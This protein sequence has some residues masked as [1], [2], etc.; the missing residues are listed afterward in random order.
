MNAAIK[1]ALIASAVFTGVFCAQK[2]MAS[3]DSLEPVYKQCEQNRV[4]LPECNKVLIQSFAD[5]AD[6]MIGGL[7]QELEKTQDD[8]RDAFQRIIKAFG[9]VMEEQ[10]A[11]I[12]SLK[13]EVQKLKA[14]QG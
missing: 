4:T 5:T 1:S 6:K 3:T 13:K 9:E 7:A 12:D 11:E 8:A 2:A 10:K 14:R